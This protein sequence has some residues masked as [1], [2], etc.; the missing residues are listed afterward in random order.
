MV[1]DKIDRSHAI[2]CGTGAFRNGS[3]DHAGNSAQPCLPM[4]KREKIQTVLFAPARGLTTAQRTSGSGRMSLH[5]FLGTWRRRLTLGAVFFVSCWALS[6]CAVPGATSGANDVPNRRLTPGSVATRET[7]TVCQ[8]GYAHSVRPRGNV[9]RRLKDE[10]YDKYGLPRGHRS[11]IDAEGH[12]HAAYEIDHLVPL[13]L[14]GAPADL[15]NLWPQPIAA[16][17]QK[18]HVENRLHVLVCAHQMTL[19]EAQSQIEN[20]WKTAIPPTNR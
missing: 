20:D 14:G 3:P 8:A 6:I 12:R 7:A 16:A 15:A 11:R 5:S 17:E 1:A 9:W 13:E 19:R 4:R 2:V 18:D 10:V